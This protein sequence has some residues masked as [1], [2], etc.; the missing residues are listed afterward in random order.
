M[1]TSWAMLSSGIKTTVHY[2]LIFYCNWF[3]SI[4]LPY[5]IILRDFSISHVSRSIWN[6]RS[7]IDTSNQKMVI[8][9]IEWA[10][11]AQ[12]KSVPE[13]KS[14]IDHPINQNTQVNAA[15]SCCCF[16]DEWLSCCC[17]AGRLVVLTP[18]E[19]ATAAGLPHITK[20]ATANG[21]VYWGWI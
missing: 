7:L 20:V 21:C 3:C 8:T 18:K 12:S 13:Y 19:E 14:K 9:I 6:Y 5:W 11:L 2:L 4:P 15:V 17:C 10:I 16:C 1:P